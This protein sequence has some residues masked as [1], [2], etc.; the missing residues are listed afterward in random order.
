MKDGLFT[1]LDNRRLYA[2]QK[3][4]KA[5][6]TIERGF[7]ELLPPELV[8]FYKVEFQPIPKTYGD[9]IKLRIGNQ[10][11]PINGTNGTYTLPFFRGK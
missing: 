6:A 3:A 1:S 5:I 4:N 10:K 7:D 9:A 8:D 2:F 11:P